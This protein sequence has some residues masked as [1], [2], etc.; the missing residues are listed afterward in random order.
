MLKKFVARKEVFTISVGDVTLNYKCRAVTVTPRILNSC[1]KRFP[2]S[3]DGLPLSIDPNTRVL[4]NHSAPAPC[5]APNVP[6]LSTEE[7]NYITLTLNVVF[8]YP[9]NQKFNKSSPHNQLGIYPDAIVREHMR[10]E[11]IQHYSKESYALTSSYIQDSKSPKFSPESHS[12][13][14]KNLNYLA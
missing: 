10:N 2:V 6:I 9:V 7:D 8:F 5:T 3:Y 12:Y 11:F 4:F 14:S 1:F 13:L